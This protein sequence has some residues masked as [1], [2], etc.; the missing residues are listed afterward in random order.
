MIFELVTVKG[1]FAEVK[2]W[3]PIKEGKHLDSRERQKFTTW[4][5][6]DGQP[7]KEELDRCFESLAERIVVERFIG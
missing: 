6:N 1:V 7:S 4:V 5:K 3:K 2:K